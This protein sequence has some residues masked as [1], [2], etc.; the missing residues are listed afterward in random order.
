M[1][2]LM[3]SNQYNAKVYQIKG[4]KVKVILSLVFYEKAFFPL[5]IH[6]Y[7][8]ILD[9]FKTIFHLMHKKQKRIDVGDMYICLFKNFTKIKKVKATVDHAVI[10]LEM[11]K[12]IPCTS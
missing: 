2:F 9:M 4:L 11:I 7:P 8:L 5:K 1:I 6:I 3:L 12:T 10:A